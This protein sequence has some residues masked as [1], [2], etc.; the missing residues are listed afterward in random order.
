MV[1][2]PLDDGDGAATAPG[3]TQFVRLH[4]AV[5]HRSAVGGLHGGDAGSQERRDRLPAGQLAR[6]A[7]QHV[8]AILTARRQPH[9]GQRADDAALVATQPQ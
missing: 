1:A 2:G 6:A 7:H 3:R 9:C 5:G 4:Q 8:A